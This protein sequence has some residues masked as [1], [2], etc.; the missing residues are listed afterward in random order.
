MQADY[1]AWFV[2]DPYMLHFMQDNMR[3]NTFLYKE[4]S[5]IRLSPK[6]NEHKSVTEKRIGVDVMTYGTLY[7]YRTRI[8]RQVVDA[9]I[10]L[11]LYGSFLIAFFDKTFAH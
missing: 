7:P 6:P 10:D 1:D 9:G 2:K 11:K 8:L 5:D 3:V 4:V